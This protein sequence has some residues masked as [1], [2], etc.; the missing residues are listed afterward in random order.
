MT[1][2]NNK[3]PSAGAKP[4]EFANYGKVERISVWV[5][6]LPDGATTDEIVARLEANQIAWGA[7][8]DAQDFLNSVREARAAAIARREAQ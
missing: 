7:E 2:D 3:S 6:S 8:E 4:R 1:A 5:L